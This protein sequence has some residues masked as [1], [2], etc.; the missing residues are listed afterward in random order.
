M[1]RCTAYQVGIGHKLHI[2][3]KHPAWAKLAAI[4]NKN[5]CGMTEV[6]CRQFRRVSYHWYYHI[7]SGKR[8]VIFSLVWL[9][10]PFTIWL[11]VVFECV[12]YL[13]L[14]SLFNRQISHQRFGHACICSN[15]CEFFFSNPCQGRFNIPKRFIDSIPPPPISCIP[16]T[17][18]KLIEYH[19]SA[20]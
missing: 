9:S 11:S 15:F 2:Q 10:T 17:Y 8:G 1:L 12:F 19:M 20:A 13:L 3:P 18:W 16:K 14:K 5:G 4:N 7:R 6:W